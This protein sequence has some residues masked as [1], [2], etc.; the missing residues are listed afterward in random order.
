[1]FEL[2]TI[3]RF[4]TRYLMA[5]ALILLLLAVFPLAA[6]A[7]HIDRTTYSGDDAYDPA[8]GH[9]PRSAGFAVTYSGDDAYDPAAGGSGFAARPAAIAGSYS[10]DD[11][12]DPAAGGL[13]ALTV[14][15]VTASQSSVAACEPAGPAVAGMY[16]GDDAYDPAAGSAPD[17]TAQALACLTDEIGMP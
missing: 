5:G 4:H 15:T 17:G 8:T 9:F 13:R 7:G 16:S 2:Q 1:M 3:R 6:A 10:G 11:A 14:F 12:Y